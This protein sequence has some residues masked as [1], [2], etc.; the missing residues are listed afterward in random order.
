MRLHFCP[1]KQHGVLETAQ[2]SPAIDQSGRKASTPL[3][4]DPVEGEKLAS[5]SKEQEEAQFRGQHLS[6][7]EAD[8]LRNTSGAASTIRA[9]P[10]VP[11]FKF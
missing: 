11:R 8:R 10:T 7:I 4:A 1:A 3:D 5:V 2:I 9:P 6:Q